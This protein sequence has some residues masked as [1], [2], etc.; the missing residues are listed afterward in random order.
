[1]KKVS[2]FNGKRKALLWLLVWG[3]LLNEGAK[4][5][6]TYLKAVSE[7]TTGW[8]KTNAGFS[9]N[10]PTE[11]TDA[12]TANIVSKPDDFEVSP[13]AIKTEKAPETNL[14]PTDEESPI[15][16]VL[17]TTSGFETYLHEE[18]T[19]IQN[20]RHITFTSDS[21]QFQSASCVRLDTGEEGITVLS[22]ERACGAPVY[23]G[24]LEITRQG[25]ALV[26]INELPLETYLES[27][28]P[29]EMPSSYA[30]EALKAQAICARTY[31]WKHMAGPGVEGFDAD[32]DDSVS[33]Q[34]YGN[35]SPQKETGQAVQETKGQILTHNHE[36]VDAY[37]FSTSGGA[38]STDE[39][40]GADKASAHLK[41]VK[42]SFDAEAP[43]S[44]WKVRIPWERLTTKV[45]E[46]TGRSSDFLS[47][48]IRRTNESDTVLELEIQTE[49]EV[50]SVEG[51]YQIRQF[52]SPEGCPIQKK[53][54]TVS[55]GSTLLPSACFTIEELSPEGLLLK[56]RGFGH[57]V[58]MSQNA[59]CEM[60]KR[61][62]SCEK[63]LSWFFKE[64]EIVNAY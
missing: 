30:K 36:P 5:N 33:F 47:A 48:R 20:G 12:S 9:A 46:F 14:H 63:I 13:A 28:V 62:Y 41:S 25:N 1:M 52:L 18:V 44:S 39:I 54:G 49:S 59:A 51:E 21:P 64:V 29:S 3:C 22:I 10:I 34:V 53:D 56:G 57:G 43:F 32:V 24:T 35:V 55:T 60:A 8:S 19:L 4:I 40:W 7:T 2:F 50:F 61:G 26:L 45:Q 27:V 31:A 6:L 42:C 38:T 16:R 11:L 58:G 23:F 17:L 37:Y 15:I